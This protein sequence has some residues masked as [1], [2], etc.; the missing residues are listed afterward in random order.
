MKLSELQEGKEYFVYNRD[1]WISATYSK[2]YSKTAEN[3]RRERMTP[4]FKDGIIQRDYKGRI[5]MKSKSGITD[6]VVLRH[7][8]SEFFDAVAL[9]TKTNQS[10]YDENKE[11]AK[12]YAQ[13]LARKAE[14]ERNTIEKPIREEFFN[15]I[16]A[17][18]PNKYVSKW[19]ELD[20][21]P[22]EVMQAIT[23]ALKK[24]EA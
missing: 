13:H 12:R 9:I 3:L 14:R 17:L 1:H 18:A 20:K 4:E 23:E 15:S 21:L 24:V 7:I 16:S 19:T 22:I 10:R 11:R 8:R 2:T 6:K 5:Y